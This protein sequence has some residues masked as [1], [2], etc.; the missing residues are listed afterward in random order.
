MGHDIAVQTAKLLEQTKGAG[1]AE[2]K[3][4]VTANEEAKLRLAELVD[5]IRVADEVRGEFGDGT[6]EL[7][8]YQDDLNKALQQGRISQEEY[9]A[10]MANATQ[11]QELQALASQRFKEGIDGLAAGFQYAAAQWMQAQS[12]FNTGQQV[13][14]GFIDALNEGIDALVG[15]SKKGFDEIAADFALMLAKMAAQKA[16]SEIFS[17]V[18][19]GFGGSLGVGGM[20]PP[21]PGSGLLGMLGGLFRANGGPVNANSPYIVGERGPEWFVPATAGRVMPNGTA[22]V[23]GDVNVTVNMAQ[24]GSGP[25]PN[26]AAEFGRRVRAAV[27]DVI[28]SEQRPGGV[29]YNG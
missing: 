16:A 25:S 14:G 24:G 1:A 17:A 23:G 27:M 3:K 5:V 11:Q 2:I 26:E 4:W 15:R 6:R 13:F 20:G 12:S 9:T 21:T 19:G 22:P 28:T 7:R 18:L 29:L 10:A 8:E